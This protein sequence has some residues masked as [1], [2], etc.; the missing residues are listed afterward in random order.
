MTLLSAETDV[1]AAAGDGRCAV[2]FLARRRSG[3]R[4]VPDPL[5]GALDALRGTGWLLSVDRILAGG[6]P[7]EP[8]VYA[9]GFSHD[10]DFVGMFE[11][12]GL[13]MAHAGIRALE[14]AGWSR[15]FRTEWLLGP[16][17]FQPVVSHSSRGTFDEWGF[18]ALWRWNNAWH[19]ATEQ[20]RREY[21]LECD[22]AFAADVQDGAAITGRHRL[23]V[24]SQWD[25]IGVWRVPSVAMVDRAMRM[26]ERVADFKFTTSRHYLGKRTAFESLLEGNV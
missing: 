1:F 13:S 2:V 20:Q 11:A 22:Q 14:H 6:G 15:L 9:T 21:D 19:A 23:D 25:H 18:F 3:G 16:R 26:H 4:G 10:V 7:N 8:S 5:A 12:P 24:A 17:E